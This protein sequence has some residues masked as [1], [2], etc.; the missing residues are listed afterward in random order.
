MFLSGIKNQK[1]VVSEANPSEDIIKDLIRMLKRRVDDWEIFYSL[2]NGLSIEAND[3]RVDAFKVS[4]NEGISLRVFKDKRIGCSFTS[5]PP[6]D[7]IGGLLSK[8]SL[9]ELVQNA[10]T[11]S[12]GVTADEFLFLP[13][14]QKTT[15]KELM[16]FDL[17]L[18]K[19]SEDDK[20]Q[21]A[22][23]L[24]RAAKGFDQRVTKIRKAGYS[25]SFFQ[26]RLVN[27][28]GIDAAKRATF[29]SS[30]VTVVAEERGEAQ[31][32]W[33]MDMSHFIKDID[34]GKIGMDAAKRAV[35]MLG[36]RTIK[37]VKCP[38]LIEN[39]VVGE[40]LEIIAPSFYADNISKGKSML[41][42]KKGAKVFNEKVTIWD[43]GLLPNGWGTSQYDGEGVTRQKTCL[44]D[45]GVCVGFLYDTY[46]AKKEGAASTGNAARHNFKSF[47]N[48]GIS[49]LYL[50]K[51]DMDFN[52]LLGNM[53]NGFLLTN[54]LG[55][56][57]VNPITG[58]FSFGASGFWIED[59]NISYPVRGAAVS[60]NMLEL[61]SK[62]E[63]IGSDM[64]FLGG[65]G[66]PSLII[67][68]MEISGAG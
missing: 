34:V 26:T 62:V 44:V 30:S 22:I 31:M 15:E 65:V 42:G 36:A 27:S 11:G 32:G 35:D 13:L 23:S 9:D 3:G 14:P 43:N 58:D 12:K 54:V 41:K 21:E 29:V 18:A 55:A 66:A 7:S 17:S 16:I 39:I 1:P 46:W 45:R 52:G 60:G 47:S 49:N 59:G 25:E 2:Q 53:R 33:E 51:G 4:S 38:V 50:E 48:I 8:D 6:I 40:F 10:I 57:T 37:T 67:S 19:I 20:I 68:D 64:R 56:H 63:I 61:F 28:V 24:E 5:L